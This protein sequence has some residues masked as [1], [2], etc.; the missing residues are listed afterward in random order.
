MP[1]YLEFF[2]GGGMVREGL[3]SDWQCVFANDF[4]H[5]K[6]A[7]YEKNWGTSKL[8][9]DDIRNIVT[10]NIPNQTDLAWASFPC[11][12]LSLAGGGA[13]LR[14]D[15]SGTFWP[16]WSLMR[17]LRNEERAPAI[18]ALE[19]VCG[20]L[21]SHNGRDFSAICEA[22]RKLGYRVGA[23]VID[24]VKFLPQ[25]RPRLFVI[26]VKNEITIPPILESLAAVNPWHTNSLI[27]AHSK[28]S[29]PDKKNWIWW[30]LPQVRNRRKTLE[31]L[32]DCDRH[33]L[34]WHT[35]KQT[36]DIL[37]MMDQ[38]NRNK[39]RQ[40]RALGHKIIGTMYR[41]TRPDPRGGTIQRIEVRFDG[42]AGCLRTPAG[43]SSRQLVIRVEGDNVRT[44][45]LSTREAA[46]LMGLPDAFELPEKYN[47]AY[48]LAGDG[49]AVPIVRYLSKR[50]F[51]P[52]LLAA[53]EEH[54]IAA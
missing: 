44:R 17:D 47:E 51:L 28:L 33:D 37:K 48:H 11:Q 19:N 13:G 12:D 1:T 20:T 23:V 9:K 21:T 3:G 32:I 43:G 22:F 38:T 35:K 15:R 36:R 42:I 41:R 34:E 27:K 16:F 5:K 52:I 39:L 2:C 6:C 29:E 14:G 50:V 30:S 45:L 54:R 7:T 10:D 40:A 24:A 31:Q 46:R 49:V 18:I 8:V 53:D 26:G 4:D 25:S